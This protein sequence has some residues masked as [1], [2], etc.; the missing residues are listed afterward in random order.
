MGGEVIYI[1]R[2]GK[3]TPKTNPAWGIKNP[4]RS[5]NLD[6]TEVSLPKDSAP[7][8]TALVSNEP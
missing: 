1:R 8:L 7:G 4:Y 5:K 2:V 6:Q 3:E